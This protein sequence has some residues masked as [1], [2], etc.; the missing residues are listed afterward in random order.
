MQTVLIGSLD[1]GNGKVFVNNKLAQT[2]GTV[3]MDMTMIDITDV[4]GVNEAMKVEIF[5]NNISV[6]QVAEWC[7]TI[8]YEILA[9]IS[10][11]VKRI[12]IE[13]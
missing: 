7:D 12:Y 6:Q 10:Q 9:G 2:I 3:S 5:G 11:R 13:E 4:P 1:P 8:P